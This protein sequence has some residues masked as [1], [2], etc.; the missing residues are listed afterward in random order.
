MSEQLTDKQREMLEFIE[1]YAK[2][3]GY[4]PT[5]QEIMHHFNF[6]SPNAVTSQLAA[7]EKKGH[8]RK[9]GR[10]ARGIE[11]L[12]PTNTLETGDLI[13]VPL[14]GSVM[15]GPNMI[16][17]SA[18]EDRMLFPKFIAREDGVFLMKVKGDSMINA[19]IADGDYVLV[20]PSIDANN[21]EIIVATYRNEDTGSDDVTVKRF[22]REKDHIRLAP[23]N[24][25][26]KPILCE[27]VTIVG[28]VIAVIRLNIQ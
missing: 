10:R 7:L 18:V 25:E 22:F 20:K 13:N 1:S 12:N 9:A 5:V 26:Y 23:E 2:Q 21:G 24:D 17:D 3:Q 15:A 14:L 28:K 4:P 6:A 11:V 19:H 8:I 27:T 16:A